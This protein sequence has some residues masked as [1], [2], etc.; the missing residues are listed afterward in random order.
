VLDLAWRTLGGVL[1][2]A[3]LPEAAPEPEPARSLALRDVATAFEAIESARGRGSRRRRQALLTA[4]FRRAPPHDRDLLARIIHGEMRLGLQ[5]ALLPE[6]IAR[7]AG[8]AEPLVRRAL[9]FLADPA[10]V[11]RMALVEGE[12]ALAGVSVRVFVPLLPMLAEPSS[13]LE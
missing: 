4:L 9:L 3:D 1:P 2:A 6:S 7:A 11:A 8:V 5:E 10:V 12:A 13:G